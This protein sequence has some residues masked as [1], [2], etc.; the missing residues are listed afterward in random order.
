MDKDINISIKTAD[1]GPAG[2][3]AYSMATL[4]AW[5]FLCGFVN[6]NALLFM[7]A[8]SLACTIP[9]LAAGISQIKLNNVAG[10]VT[11]I[12]FGAF[13]AFCSAECYL[14]SYFAPIHGWKLNTEI[15]GFQWAVLAAVLIL[16]TPV[17]LKYSPLAASISVL[18]ADVGL[19]TLALIYWGFT[20]LAQVSGWAFFVAG[21]TGIVMTAGGI[22]EGAAMKF[23][24]GRPIGNYFT[25]ALSRK[26]TSPCEDL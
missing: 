15:L 21:V 1:A 17:F 26:E 18:A 3:M 4:I 25:R 19:L 16:T 7:A 23:S 22:L 8:I 13:F 12:Y 2:W 5:P 6:H 24:M 20:D 14:I 11:W 9:Y 10:G